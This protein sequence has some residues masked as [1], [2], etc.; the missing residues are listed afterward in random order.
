MTEARAG[1]W[2]CPNGC[3]RERITD[4]TTPYACADC[5][6]TMEHQRDRTVQAS[7]L[8]SHESA[9]GKAM[10]DHTEEDP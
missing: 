8:A 3:R 6:A 1:L 2:V 7:K 9:V 10:Q 5:G 4:P